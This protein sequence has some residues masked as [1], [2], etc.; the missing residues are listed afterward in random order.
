MSIPCAHIYFKNHSLSKFDPAFID[1][2]IFSE[3]SANH[4]SQAYTPSDL[5]ELIGPFCTSPLRLVPKLHSDLFHMIQDMS[6]PQDKP[7][8]IS[9]NAGINSNNFLTKWGILD[10]TAATII[11][12]PQGCVAA[13]FNITATYHLTPIHPDQQHC[14]CVYWKSKVYVD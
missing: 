5:K 6:Y 7:N 11:T 10:T 8:I 2:Y 12:L 4:Y 13:R 1:V 3:Q 9:V 14:L